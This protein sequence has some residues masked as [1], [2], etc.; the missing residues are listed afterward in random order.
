MILHAHNHEWYLFFHNNE[1]LSLIS[2]K[3]VMDCKVQ[4]ML[5]QLVSKL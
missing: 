3:T 5:A 1:I 2:I 4:S